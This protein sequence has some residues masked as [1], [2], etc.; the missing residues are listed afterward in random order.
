MMYLIFILC[1]LGDVCYLSAAKFLRNFHYVFLRSFGE[2]NV[3]FLN[4]CIIRVL[5]RF[6][7]SRALHVAPPVDRAT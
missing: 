4:N 6:N 3:Y 2:R 5:C 7:R 1:L